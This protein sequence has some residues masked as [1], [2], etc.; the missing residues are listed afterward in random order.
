MPGD[1]KT[2]L[3]PGVRWGVRWAPPGHS[4][5]RKSAGWHP[6]TRASAY[7][8]STAGNLAPLSQRWIVIHDTPARSAACF[9]VR[10]ACARF[11]RRRAA[12]SLAV[13]VSMPPSYTARKKIP[14]AY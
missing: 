4:G 11:A 5:G 8:T 3:S 9:W 12:I 13:A 2:P 6:Y 10:S 14:P 7:S 1:R